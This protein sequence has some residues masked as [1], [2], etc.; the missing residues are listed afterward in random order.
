VRALLHQ[1]AVPEHEDAIGVVDS[2][3]HK[4]ENTT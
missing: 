3:S 4:C 1:L 2:F